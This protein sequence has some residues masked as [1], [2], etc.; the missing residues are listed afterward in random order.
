[1]KSFLPVIA[2]AL[3]LSG[4]V[5]EEFMLRIDPE[6]QTPLVV[7]ALLPLSGTNRIYAEQMR[8]GL[9]CAESDINANGGIGRRKL[10]LEILDTAGTAAGT[11]DAVEKAERLNA[12]GMIAGYSTEE[13]SMIITHSARLRM[14][15]VIPL[16]TSMYHL[17]VSPFVYRNSYSDAQQMEVLAAY[18]LSWRDLR[19]G[20]VLIDP[21]DAPEYSR[22]IARNFAQAVTDLGGEIVQT[23]I[24]PESGEVP[25]SLVRELLAR[26]PEFIIIPSQGKRAANI[27]KTLRNNGFSGILCGPD[28]WD[29]TEFIDALADFEPGDCIYT[30]FFSPENPSAEFAEFRRKFRARFFHNP[31]ACETQSYDALKF[32]AIGLAGVDN[33]PDFDKNWRSIRN[34]NG[35]AAI[36]TMLKKG[37]ID[38]TIYLNS[39]G[40]RRGSGKLVP[41]A[42][43]SRK[44]QYSKLEDYKI[45]ETPRK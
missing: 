34:H 7:A 44:L 30:A 8:E 17:Q 41:Y 21:V 3:L 45:T 40:V 37:E 35:A 9:L 18:L 22:G 32:L 14:P 1:M 36:Y 27:L 2:A 33:L 43:L 15:T 10:Q 19:R 38:R 4:C 20:V 12:V 11:R 31:E 5:P 16:A 28:S 39:I 25:F 29:D 13:V 24:L 42:R 6:A 26:A 23:T